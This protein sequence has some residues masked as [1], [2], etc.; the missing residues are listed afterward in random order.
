MIPKII[1]QTHDLDYKDLPEFMRELMNTWV[2]LNPGYKHVYMNSIERRKYIE[3]NYPI[4]LELFDVVPVQHKADLWR[5]CIVYDNGG[6]YADTDSV[7]IQSIDNAVKQ[8]TTNQEM[9]CSE[10]WHGTINNANFA[11]IKNS[12]VL[13]EV[14]KKITNFCIESK[15]N[16]GPNADGAYSIGPRF[17]SETIL[18]NK[19]KSLFIMNDFSI[20]GGRA[21]QDSSRI[22]NTFYVKYFDQTVDYKKFFKIL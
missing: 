3:D 4:L 13:S 2:N 17:F 11:A 6:V 18:D 15:G 12:T 5:Y 8:M 19:H 21:K 7:C 20:H 16:F 10:K 14:L 1:F 22:R 9:I